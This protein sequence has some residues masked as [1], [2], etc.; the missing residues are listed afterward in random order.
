MGFA[1]DLL[2]GA[3]QESVRLKLRGDDMRKMMTI[4]KG[5]K[6]SSLLI[7]AAS[8]LVFGLAHAQDGTQAVSVYARLSS[9]V[10]FID[11]FEFD[12]EVGGGLLVFDEPTVTDNKTGYT[13]GAALGFDYGRHFRTELEYRYIQSDLGALQ[14]VFANTSRATIAPDAQV[15]T[16][17]IMSNVVYEFAPDNTFTPFVSLGLGGAFVSLDQTAGILSANNQDAALAY[18]AKGGV[19]YDVSPSISIALDYTYFATRDLA[20]GND[21]LVPGPA[22]SQPS[23]LEGDNFVASSVQF[24]IQKQF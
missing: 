17:A 3:V 4:H 22:I 19:K 9:G 5:I 13:L 21:E 14:Q 23:T 8:P 10:S 1:R 20:F 7:S 18:Q 11:K 2:Y 16:H 12:R 6:L 24:S 15:T